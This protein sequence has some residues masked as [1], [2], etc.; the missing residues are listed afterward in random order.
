MKNIT[1]I[2]ID[3]DPKTK[4]A[5][6]QTVTL[7]AQLFD[8]NAKPI[9]KQADLIEVKD[10][11]TF[12]WSA[13]PNEIINAVPNEPWNAEWVPQAQG[14]HKITLTVTGKTT[15]KKISA[16]PY[17]IPIESRPFSADEPLTVRLAPAVSAQ[18][19]DDVLFQSIRESSASLNFASYQKFVDRVMCKGIDPA[20]STEKGAFDRMNG[21]ATVFPG[22]DAYQRL[23]VATEVYLMLSVR[24]V[25]DDKLLGY[26]FA[27][28]NKDEHKNK[29]GQ[30]LDLQELQSQWKTY[31]KSD[32]EIQMLPVD[33]LIR[34]KL[35]EHIISADTI[36]AR[37]GDVNKYL[38]VTICQGIL[39]EKL[40]R[41]CF[42][43]LIWSYWH[44]EGMLVQTMKSIALRFQNQ[45][46]S[47]RDPLASFD[48]SP[49]YPLNNLLWSY[50][51]DEQ[52]RL[53]VRRR[54]YEYD[55]HY[56][57]A[58]D[59]KVV[60]ALQSADSRSK[61][62]EAFHNLLHTSLLFFKQD[63]D[64]T[65][66]ADGFP[67]LNGLKEVHLLLREGMHNQFGDLPST[68]R[69]EMLMEQWL[70][71]RPEMQQF[72]GGRAMMPY[73]EDWMDRVD[74]MKKLKG[75]SD[76][77]VTYFSDLGKFGEQLLRARGC[78]VVIL[79][80]DYVLG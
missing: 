20:N 24:V 48:I 80:R 57:I 42:F 26:N 49:L 70:L 74:T 29:H 28:Y 53:T 32:G 36:R 66:K 58:L 72:L 41:P 59:G 61:F 63:D 51:Q 45:R 5:Q 62:I 10:E 50:I 13:G 56:G 12:A 60:P 3:I 15:G 55:H 4:I 54:A 33:D 78:D 68:A 79:Q 14:P 47:E 76:V 30:S 71:A 73:S 9:L 21:R 44:E 34:I 35:K 27:A 6:G 65:I 19:N 16:Q 2:T 39:G 77:S 69:Q 43:E 75:W 40:R 18:T 38:D 7:M 52:H 46:T 37:N 64:T 1:S 67:V 23:K 17:E 22:M 8:N 31:L 11:H 25:G